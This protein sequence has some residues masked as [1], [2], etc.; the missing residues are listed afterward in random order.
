[1]QPAIHALT[2]KEK[3]TL[4][5]LVE[6]YD[7]K[8]MARHLGLS[9]HT[10]NE[11]LRDARRKLS[12]PSSREAARLLREAEHRNP[13]LL[14]DKA[15]GD[16]PGLEPGADDTR[17]PI[18]SASTRRPVWLIGG[19]AMSFAL[20]L[21]ALTSLGGASQIAEPVATAAAA[22]PHS[23]AETEAV[24]AARRWLE[25]VDAKDWK[26]SYELTGNAFRTANT[27]EGWTNAALSVHGKFGPARRRVL[28]VA[29]ETPAP[30]AGNV[31]VK[32]RASYANK[33]E[34]TELLTLVR[35]DGAWKVSGIFV[36]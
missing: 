32:F 35:E 14:G 20:T 34:G 13:E 19:I 31:V 1:M 16:A 15:L 4:R 36:D 24:S 22:S 3:Q 2:E 12:T 21:A 27:L 18:M 28:V 17:Q 25:L 8:S 6:G 10:V 29:E 33:P 9:V 11:R 30:P 23:T 5:L 26:A 7:A